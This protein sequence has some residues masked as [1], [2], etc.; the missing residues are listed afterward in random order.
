M[1]KNTILLKDSKTKDALCDLM[2]TCATKYHYTVQSCVVG[3]LVGSPIIEIGRTNRKDYVKDKVGAINIKRCFLVELVDRF[4]KLI[5]ANT[6]CPV[7][8]QD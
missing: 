1:V 7:F 4:V 6:G 8:S 3:S 5:L 2:G